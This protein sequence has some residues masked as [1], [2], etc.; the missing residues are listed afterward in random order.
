[1]SRAPRTLAALALAALA[2][3]AGCD[4]K[5]AQNAAPLSRVVAVKADK[6]DDTAG[7]CDVHKAAE[8]AP[9]FVLPSVEEGELQLAPGRPRWVNVWATWCPPCVEE[10]GLLAKAK[11]SADGA[12]K[13]FDLTFISVDVSREVI[14]KFALVHPE[15]KGSLRAVDPQAI[16]AWLPKVGL[17]TGAT[18]PIHLFVDGAGRVRCA[19][20]GGVRDTDLPRI[21]KLLEAL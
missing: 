18:L 12:A 3:L 14:D 6:L 4:D 9:A 20:T 8:G 17:D 10:L 16:E 19:R 21:H 5:A 7:L 13:P 11:A 15:A 2:G 1:M